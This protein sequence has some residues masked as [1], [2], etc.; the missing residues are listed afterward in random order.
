MNQSNKT[1]SN[2]YGE[3]VGEKVLKSSN[4][5]RGEIGRVT[6][7]KR[8]LYTYGSRVLFCGT[9]RGYDE[10]DFKTSQALQVNSITHGKRVG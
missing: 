3:K 8:T 10:N 4:R 5:Q 7:S 9:R 1:L 2:T 6:I